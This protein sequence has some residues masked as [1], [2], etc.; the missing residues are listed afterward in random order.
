MSTYPTVGGS[1]MQ[2]ADQP[3]LSV[4]EQG[5]ITLPVDPWS[6]NRAL[7]IAVG[8]F[9][10]MANFRNTSGHDIRLQIAEELYLG[11]QPKKY[12]EGTRIPRSSLGVP[13]SMDQV[14]ALMPPIM[15]SIFPLRD[16][17]DISPNP[18]TSNDEAVATFNVIMSQLD[19]DNVREKVRIAAKQGLIYANGIIEVTW[20]YQK[21][22]KRKI[23]ARWISPTKNVFDPTTGQVVQTQTGQ[24]RRVLQ[25]TTEEVE[26]NMPELIN[27]PAQDF[28][29]DPNLQ[30]NDIQQ[31]RMAA[32]RNY[33][34]IGDLKQLRGTAGFQIPEDKV[35]IAMAKST[36]AG[37]YQDTIK[38]MGETYRYGSWQPQNDYTRNPD[39]WRIEVIRY[40]TKERCVWV[41]NRMWVGYNAPSYGFIPFL[42]AFYVD[43]PNRFYGYAVT[44]AVE[45]EQR[46]QQ[47]TI[48]ARIDELNLTINAP[49]IMTNGAQTNSGLSA[50]NYPGKVWKVEKKD[51]ITRMEM[52]N[53]TQNAYL[54]VEASDRRAQKRTGVSDLS[55]L[56][57][58][59]IGGNSANRTATGVGVQDKAASQRIKYQVENLES[60]FIEPLLKMVLQMNQMFLNPEQILQIEGQDGQYYQVDPMHVIN[61]DVKFKIRGSDKMRSRMMILQALPLITQTYFNPAFLDALGT[62]QNMTLD[63][64]SWDRL[65][66]DAMQVPAMSLL[67]QMTPQER[68]Q[69]QMAKM[70]PLMMKQ[71]ETQAKLQNQAQ[72]HQSSDETQLL[73]A[74]LGAIPP[75][76]LH[77]FLGTDRSLLTSGKPA[78]KK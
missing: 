44:D 67:R 37:T 76:A 32:V 41:F 6:N 55:V 23:T 51:D 60:N 70:A 48:N 36:K 42:N 2:N 22:A 54:E 46:L 30:T 50:R 16:N 5:R 20:K 34:T 57:T 59:S 69:Q 13:I 1:Q 53:V 25:E 10:E 21:I 72:I 75:E 24:P 18:G 58:S 31:A 47:A 62:Q 27:V 74:I 68:Q 28:F 19:T 29:I 56:G 66:S 4:A 12:W 17:V 65:L 77:Q 9:E 43:V 71:Q 3:P 49:F 45:G 15:G 61:A 35:L 40:H 38:A 7:A 11:W 14:E 73:T 78:A 52:G 63:M 64:K 39:S 26:T 33:A 8:D